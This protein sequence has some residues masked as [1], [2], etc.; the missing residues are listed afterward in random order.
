MSKIQVD[1]LVDKRK[2]RELQFT[3]IGQKMKF[4][5]DFIIIGF[6]FNVCN[7]YSIPVAENN[8]T[9]RRNF[10]NGCKIQGMHKKLTMHVFR[11]LLRYHA[12][13]NVRF[14]L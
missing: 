11:N 6:F 14:Y 10:K 3:S 2:L 8:S 9:K 5:C 4:S 13:K 7:I 1:L 12:L